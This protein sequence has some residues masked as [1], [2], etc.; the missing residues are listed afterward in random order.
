M[1]GAELPLSDGVFGEGDGTG[2]EAGSGATRDPD[3]ETSDDDIA[4]TPEN[5]L[6][7]RT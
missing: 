7:P 2:P 3:L 4:Q 5:G 6:R 1:G